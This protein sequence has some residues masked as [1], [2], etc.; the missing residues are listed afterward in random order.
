MLL[1][2][3]RPLVKAV[4]YVIDAEELTCQSDYSGCD[5]QMIGAK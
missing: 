3:A 1:I 4:G 5:E 2:L